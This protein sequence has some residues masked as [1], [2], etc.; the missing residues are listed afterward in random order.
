MAGLGRVQDDAELSQAR[1]PRPGFPLPGVRYDTRPTGLTRPESAAIGSPSGRNV[2]RAGLESRLRT[3]S[4]GHVAR[5]PGRPGVA[6]PGRKAPRFHWSG[7]MVWRIRGEQLA[8]L[9]YLRK[10]INEAFPCLATLSPSRDVIKATTRNRRAGHIDGADGRVFLR[11]GFRCKI[12][13]HLTAIPG[14]LGA[15]DGS[16]CRDDSIFWLRWF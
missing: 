2:T 10:E 1:C 5:T 6:A 13:R 3:V 12:L 4:T 7:S 16:F 15:A 11:D 8:A 9:I 14:A